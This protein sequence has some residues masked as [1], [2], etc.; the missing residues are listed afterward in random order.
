[1]SQTTDTEL[2]V[3]AA[4]THD[5]AAEI[6]DGE[7]YIAVFQ[8]DRPRGSRTHTSI[9]GTGYSSIDA[10]AAECRELATADDSDIPFRP[11]RVEI[12][13][14]NGEVTFDTR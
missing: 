11:H 14:S 12:F 8:Q 4:D 3:T 2:T 1:M 9:L 13:S 6:V 7:C 10:L 5:A